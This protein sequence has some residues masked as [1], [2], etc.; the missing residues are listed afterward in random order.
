MSL[1]A[2][3]ERLLERRNPSGHWEGRL[4][5]SALS[6][7]TAVVAL[8]TAGEREFVSR[9]VTWLVEHQN[10]DGGW[11]DTVLSRSNIS[12]T[13]LCWAAL[14]FADSPDAHVSVALDRA[15]SWLRAAAGDTTPAALSAAIL[16]RYGKDKTF[17][18]AIL[19]VLAITGRLGSHAR[20]AWRM[21]PQ[22]PFELE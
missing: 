20:A 11:G 9:G 7:A 19:T 12:T 13:A 5:S 22:L 2:L 16:R 17:S 8:A 14:S 18:V 10:T 3:V 1:E 6:T 15:L 4:S 21:V